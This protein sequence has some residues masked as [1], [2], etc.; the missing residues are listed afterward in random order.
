MNK[1]D[2]S[3]RS[4]SAEEE[5]GEEN[6]DEEDEE[7]D[8]EDQEG[9]QIGSTGGVNDGG[10]GSGGG[11]RRRKGDPNAPLVQVNWVQ[12]NRCSKWRKAPLS[13]DPESLP[14]IWH[15]GMNDWA[16]NMAKC[17]AKEE[18]DEPEPMREY[19][20][21]RH[22]QSKSRRQSAASAGT[23]LSPA[24]PVKKVI[25]WVQCERK[26]CK[27]WRKVPGH[28]NMSSLPEMWYCE[29]NQ[30]DPDR[31][32]CDV[33]DDSDDEADAMKQN[34][35]AQLI[36]GNSKGPS[37]LSYRR[38]IFGTDGKVRPVYSEKN[39]NGYGIFSYVE[40]RRHAEKHS[41]G[42]ENAEPTTRLS[43][44]WSSV[45]DETGAIKQ[46]EAAAQMARPW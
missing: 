26:T 12:C 9:W 40:S 2:A 32:S 25:Q 20:E 18:E 23:P 35:N 31:A 42:D 17:S 37:A 24:G 15:C 33:P 16:P 30:W 19:G 22:S 36:A 29:M 1:W 3:H 7:G 5:T 43:Y 34:I 41:N 6:Q 44:W 14:D 11:K 4:C 10:G 38:I 21:G 45:Y 8:G 28:V 46:I 13:I 39:K 27:K